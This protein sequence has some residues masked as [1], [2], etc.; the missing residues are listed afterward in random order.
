MSAGLTVLG[1]LG[2]F[3]IGMQVMTDGLRGMTGDALRA[4]LIRSTRSPASGVLTGALSTALIQSSSATTVMAVGFVSAGLL[5]FHQALGIIFG[6]NIGT[7]MTGWIVALIGFKLNLGSVVLPLALAGA[8]LKLFST[9]K[10]AHAGWALAGFSLIFM[11]ID[12]LQQGMSAWQDH[13]T[14]DHFPG[15]SWSG[16]LQMVAIGMLITLVTQSSSA[17]VAAALVAL[18]TGTL[19]FPQAAA[20]VIGMDIGTT[21]TAFLATLGGATTTRRTGYAHIVYNLLTGLLALVLLSPYAVLV[22]RLIDITRPGN[23]QLALV[24]FHTGFNMVGVVVV[25]CFTSQFILL[26][27]RLVPDPEGDLDRLLDPT[28][29]RDGNAATDAATA[30][31]QHLGLLMIGQLDRVAALDRPDPQTL[32]RSDHQIALTLDFA[33]R[34]DTEADTSANHRL[35][36]VLHAIDH[37]HRLKVR[38]DHPPHLSSAALAQHFSGHLRALHAQIAT[39]SDGLAKAGDVAGF[40]HLR[41]RFR[42]DRFHLRDQG[43]AEV[44]TG[45]LTAEQAKDRF[46]TMRWLH[47]TSYHAWRISWHLH[48]C[49]RLDPVRPLSGVETDRPQMQESPR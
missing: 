44:S 13:V 41:Q 24:A 8:L 10:W 2:L 42:Q 37:L 34:I 36:S 22:D 39:L 31:I 27:E 33:R 23:A 9:R 12:V 49:T 45:C 46:D 35:Q 5:G 7:T 28:L 47:R 14:P 43:I 11:G 4:Y 21:A 20:M 15:D 17:G 18:G 40:D 1:G 38:L 30:M 3:L 19:S 25:L 26:M 48:N 29:L 32:A 6:A 16:R